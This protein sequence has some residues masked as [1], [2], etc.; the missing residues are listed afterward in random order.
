MCACACVTGPFASW[1]VKAGRTG[2]AEWTEMMSHSEGVVAS[3]LKLIVVLLLLKKLSVNFTVLD[4]YWSVF[5][6]P[7]LGKVL[8]DV[9]TMTQLQRFPLIIWT[10]FNLVL[11]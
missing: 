8:E 9:V 4:N 6:L 7:F 11:G 3:C 2:L 1:L 10:L 5:N